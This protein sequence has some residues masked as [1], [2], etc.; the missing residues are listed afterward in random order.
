[1]VA[2][3][4]TST[5][6]ADS[7]AT[8]SGSN[9]ITL[10]IQPS[11]KLCEVA[12]ITIGGL[13]GSG[14][15]SD[16]TLTVTDSGLFGGTGVW[17]QGGGTLVLTV[18]SG[19]VVASGSTST[20]SFALTNP[21]AAQCAQLPTVTAGTTRTIASGATGNPVLAGTGA[22]LTLCGSM[23]LD[24]NG[25][26]DIMDDQRHWREFGSQWRCQHHLHDHPA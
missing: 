6:A 25:D 2:G 8:N 26:S 20:F 10:T 15:A 13:T 18:A 5:V 19:Q 11:A 12:T 4:W 22:P 14:L 1:M 17:T 21:A 7:S 23:S 3:S 9:T 16:A 24:T